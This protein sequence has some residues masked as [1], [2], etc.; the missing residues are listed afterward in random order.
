VAAVAAVLGSPSELAVQEWAGVA[1]GE[2][3]PK[4]WAVEGYLRSLAAEEEGR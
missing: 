4:A 3:G 1:E 2:A